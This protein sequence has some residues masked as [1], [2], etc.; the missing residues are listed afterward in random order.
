M[1][2][3][4]GRVCPPHWLG[5]AQTQP[6]GADG[7]TVAASSDAVLEVGVGTHRLLYRQTPDADLS[8]GLVIGL[9]KAEERGGG[10]GTGPH[11]RAEAGA[12]PPLSELLRGLEVPP[13]APIA[14]R[15]IGRYGRS[16]RNGSA[17]SRTPICPTALNRF[18]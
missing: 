9:A 13:T 8:H 1:A 7:R 6:K 11:R 17:D 5:L 10:P 15:L 4:A 3:K 2:V 14:Y 16:C 12:S 18:S